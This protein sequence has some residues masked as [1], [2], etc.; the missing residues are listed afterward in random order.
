[1]GIWSAV[2]YALNSTL[3]TSGFKSLD[4]L[5]SDKISSAQNTIKG[6]KYVQSAFGSSVLGTG[7]SNTTTIINVTGKGELKGLVIGGTAMGSGSSSV[8]FY[9]YPIIIVDGITLGDSYW[10][11]W[12]GSS[13]WYS[14]ATLPITKSSE[15]S[16]I[17]M[18]TLTNEYKFDTSNSLRFEKSLQVQIVTKKDA[19]SSKTIY[20]DYLLGYTTGV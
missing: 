4:K 6:T 12:G 20:Y 2:K 16:K 8:K 18:P 1:M 9:W 15:S 14:Y 7:A 10:S 11:S 13:G 17:P 19:S 5:I 3:G